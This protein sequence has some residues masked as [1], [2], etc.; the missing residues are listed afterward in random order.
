MNLY[1]LIEN[2]IV[3]IIVGFTKE[4]VLVV[5]KVQGYQKKIVLDTIP[6]GDHDIVLG[7]LWLRKYNP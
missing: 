6:L 5:I 3:I 2:L 1:W 4:I 7:A